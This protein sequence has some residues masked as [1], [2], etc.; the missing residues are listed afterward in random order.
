MTQVFIDYL[1]RYYRRY[2]PQEKPFQIKI[3]T[4]KKFAVVIE[5]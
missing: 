2:L 4:G 3:D 5:S 1:S